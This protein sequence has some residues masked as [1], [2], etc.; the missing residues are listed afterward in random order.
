MRFEEVDVIQQLE[1]EVKDLKKT[2]DEVEEQH[3]KMNDFWSNAMELS[4]LWLYRTVAKF[5]HMLGQLWEGGYAVVRSL[6]MRGICWN[7]SGIFVIT[8]CK[9]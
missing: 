1:R 2:S 9:V 6:L 7:Q 4:E 3:Q 5:N 8:S